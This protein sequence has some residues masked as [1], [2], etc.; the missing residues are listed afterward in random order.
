MGTTSLCPRTHPNRASRRETA[1]HPKNLL[2]LCFLKCINSPPNADKIRHFLQI[3][4]NSAH[5]YRALFRNF[6]ND[7]LLTERPFF[8]QNT[9][10][11]I[12]NG[13]RLIPPFLKRIET[14]TDKNKLRVSDELVMHRLNCHILMVKL[15]FAN[16]IG[17]LHEMKRMPCL[18]ERSEEH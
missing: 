10:N 8:L 16:T 2:L 11:D 6:C 9:S 17:D 14:P 15:F 18:L 1:T 5:L 7:L 4:R 3:E 12:C 13:P